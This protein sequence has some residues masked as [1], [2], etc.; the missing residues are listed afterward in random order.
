M[1]FTDW[2][3]ALNAATEALARRGTLQRDYLDANIASVEQLVRGI[4]PDDTEPTDGAGACIVVNIAAEHVPSFCQRSINGEERPYLNAYKL[5][6]RVSEKRQWVDDAI[7]AACKAHGAVLD[8][9][10]ICFA[11]VETN[12]A[13]IRFFGDI[14]L[15]LKY[16]PDW[17]SLQ[18]MIGFRP[19]GPK[20]ELRV[21]ER[22]SYDVTRAPIAE[23]VAR[24][25]A[26]G[27]SPEEARAEGISNWIG[28]WQEDLIPILCRRLLQELPATER[29]W[30]SGQIAR[31]VLDDEDYCEVLFPQSFGAEDLAEV[32]ITAGDVAAEADI[33]S[34]ERS[35]EAPS[36]HEI[37]WRDQRRAARRKLLRMG[38]P[39]RVVA[40]NA[41]RRGG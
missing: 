19:S 7:V 14:C 38:V 40:T 28:S 29:R 2:V 26:A 9:Q 10:E 27:L 13:G 8:K 20:Q 36:S 37:I 5:G 22:N 16:R 39:M 30:T 3:E 18:P 21:L 17:A 15:V 11:A 4:G 6:R 24:A 41:R 35:G 32:R 33:T 31:A 25:E 23:E 1:A 34:R 12:G